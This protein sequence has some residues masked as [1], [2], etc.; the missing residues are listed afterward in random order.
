MLLLLLRC[1]YVYSLL[2]TFST[3]KVDKNREQEEEKREE[4]GE[5]KR[6]E[7]EKDDGEKEAYVE[8]QF[9]KGI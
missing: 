8:V 3:R 5:D 1:W 7:K 4:K 9:N 6:E 2:F